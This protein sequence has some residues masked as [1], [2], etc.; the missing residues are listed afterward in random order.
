MARISELDTPVAIIDTQRMQHNIDRMQ[1]RMDALGVKF[2][3]LSDAKRLML[4]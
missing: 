3:P 4:D 2:C 1:R